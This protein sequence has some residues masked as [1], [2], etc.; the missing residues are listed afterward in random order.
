MSDKR[1]RRMEWQ[2]WANRVSIVVLIFFLL[3]DVEEVYWT[4]K[5]HFPWWDDVAEM[6]TVP[7]TYAAYFIRKHTMMWRYDL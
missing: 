1:Y 6:V 2:Y 5:Y 3:L 7:L 4:I